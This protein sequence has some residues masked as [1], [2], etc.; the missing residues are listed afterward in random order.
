MNIRGT[1]TLGPVILLLALIS[2]SDDDS[3]TGGGGT[4][5]T[6]PPAIASVNSVDAFHEVTFT[7]PVTKHP[8]EFTGNYTT[9]FAAATLHDDQKTV[10]L[11]SQGSMAGQNIDLTVTG[12]SDLHGN[13]IGTPIVESFTGSDT[14]DTTPP[15]V[16]SVSPSPDAVDTPMGAPVII[17]LSDVVRGATGSSGVTWLS[18]GASSDT[19]PVLKIR[20]SPG[21]RVGA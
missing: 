16:I 18:G 20:S 13:A 14:P 19:M 2:C 3:P 12:V 6:T 8:A 10:T 7:E 4:A 1:S 5:D 21:V 9:G 11:A 17:R 15:Q